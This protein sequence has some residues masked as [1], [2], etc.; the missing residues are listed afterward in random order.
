MLPQGGQWPSTAYNVKSVG[1]NGFYWKIKKEKKTFVFFAK[2]KTNK[3]IESH[4]YFSLI[5][6]NKTMLCWIQMTI[7]LY[8]VPKLS[9]NF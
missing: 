1:Q 9:S 2:G 4:E 8:K 6:P 7:P 3:R 5:K